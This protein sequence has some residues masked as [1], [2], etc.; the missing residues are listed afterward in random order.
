MIIERHDF[1][2]DMNRSRDLTGSLSTIS[3]NR[4]CGKCCDIG[5]LFSGYIISDGRAG[6][7]FYGG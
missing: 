2:T 7:C 6:L 4:S 3:S 5:Y 1:L